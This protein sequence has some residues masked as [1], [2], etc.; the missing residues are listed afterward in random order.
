L[1]LETAQIVPSVAAATLLRMVISSE[2]LHTPVRH[3]RAVVT[4][5]VNVRFTS[6]QE[7]VLRLVAA[8]SGQPIGAVVRTAVTAWATSHVLA[9]P[10]PDGEGNAID[11]DALVAEVEAEVDAELV[12]GEDDEP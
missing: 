7:A 6:A 5:P 4:T 12:V 1:S 2:D 3:G 9:E 8:E 11:I 10:G